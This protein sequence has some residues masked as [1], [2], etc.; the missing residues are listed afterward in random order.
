MPYC[1]QCGKE[2]NDASTNGLCPECSASAKAAP[3]KKKT[4]KKSLCLLISAI[5]GIAYMI[6]GISY[7]SNL[8]ATQTD[9]SGAIGAGIATA[10]VIPHMIC[11]AIALIF[12]ILAWAMDHRGFALTAGILYAVSIVLFFAYFMF[13]I[14]EMILCFVGYARL[15]KINQ[16]NAQIAQ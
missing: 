9:A 11:A 12:N 1:T 10:L 14:I 2:L 16:N 15:K 8:N 4:K 5:I 7:W 6:Y 13:V 3:A